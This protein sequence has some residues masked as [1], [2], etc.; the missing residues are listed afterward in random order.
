MIKSAHIQEF[1]NMIPDYLTLMDEYDRP[2][3]T[4]PISD[5]L[6]KQLTDD[7]LDLFVVVANEARS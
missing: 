7:I 1:G 6:S 5:K 2:V 3:I 4:V